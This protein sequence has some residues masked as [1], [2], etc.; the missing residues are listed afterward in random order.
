[1]KFDFGSGRVLLAVSG[2]IDS[3][4]ML[5]LALEQGV[6]CGVAHFDHG[7]RQDSDTHAAY[8]E[9]VCEQKG[10][11]FFCE[12]GNLGS[13]ASEATAREARYEFLRRVAREHGYDAIATAHHFD[14]LVETVIINILRGTGRNGF[15]SLRS[16]ELLRRPLLE[17]TQSDIIRM[18]QDREIAWVQDSSNDTDDYLR[19]RIRHHVIPRLI[20]Q[21]AYRDFAG[22]IQKTRLLNEYINR[23]L[24]ELYDDSESLSFERYFYTMIGPDVAHEL[25]HYSVR[26]R[27]GVSLERKHITILYHFLRTAGIH[28]ELVVS[29]QFT[30]RAGAEHITLTSVTPLA[31]KG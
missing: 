20:A 25:L 23:E 13:N 18:A 15:S 30:A 4:V 26:E 12:A 14:D 28:K 2:G 6:D 21:D 9:Y 19:N 22:H 10:V 17:Y 11:A 1:M 16:T 24:A 31:K 8:V 27:F 7:I 29:P 3:M 5:E